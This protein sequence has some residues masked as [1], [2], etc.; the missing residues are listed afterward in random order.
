MSEK[1]RLPGGEEIGT[2][3]LMPTFEQNAAR[4]FYPVYGEEN[5]LDPKDIEKALKGDVYKTFRRLRSPY[6]LNQANLGSCNAQATVN[7][8]HNRRQ[9]DGLKHVPLSPNHLYMHIN[10]GGDNGSLL[11]DSLAH[12]VS[13][14]ISPRQL[15]IDGN[16]VTFPS[17]VYSKRQI[18][19]TLLR[20]A[21]AAATS[22]VSHEAFRLPID[23][24]G[25]FKIALASAL[26]RDHAVIH[27]W[28]VGNASM[29]LR[30]GY[31]VVG[32]GMGNHA[33]LFHSAKWVGGDD[34]VHPDCENSWGP[35]KDILYGPV[36]NQGW[37]EDGFG[38][39]TM[40][41]AYAVAKYHTYWVLPGTKITKNTEG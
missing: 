5:Y 40:Q 39:F 37:G 17:N 7:A 14:G 32:K 16:L 24:Y 6:V 3:L 1:F 26:A 19:T 25:T 34:L 30:N 4:L 12:S 13:K 31:A 41:D 28:H 15:K 27:A 20:E 36:S 10:G 18:S 38:L 33:T 2:G 8:F 35:S 23:S 22:F 11:Q 29:N 9:L 21:D